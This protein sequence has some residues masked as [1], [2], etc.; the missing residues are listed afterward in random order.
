MQQKVMVYTTATRCIDSSDACYFKTRPS[1][2]DFGVAARFG[3]LVMGSTI[4]I[5]H[6]SPHLLQSSRAGLASAARPKF[7]N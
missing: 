4:R 6:D 3:K 1:A 7:L 2:R 5:V